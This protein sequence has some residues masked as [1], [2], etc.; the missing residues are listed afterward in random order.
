VRIVEPDPYR[1]SIASSLGITTLDP[2]SDDVLAS[3]E[4]WTDG[5]GADVAFEVSGSAQGV[6]NAVASL[7]ARGRLCLVAIHT[8]P[9]EVDLFRFFWRELTLVGARLYEREDFEEAVRLVAVGDIPARQL[10]T[11][12]EGLSDA[13]HAFEL[14]ESDASV[15]KVLIDCQDADH[16]ATD[17]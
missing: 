11:H 2:G 14:L 15:M 7:R 16:G 17:E 8:E 5:A 6:Q 3:V 12:V 1:R 4:Q 9:R 10:I 13:L